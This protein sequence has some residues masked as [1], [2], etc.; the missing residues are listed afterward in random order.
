[1]DLGAPALIGP[2]EADNTIFV[3]LDNAQL[4]ALR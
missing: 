3:V 4:I 1:M 2:I